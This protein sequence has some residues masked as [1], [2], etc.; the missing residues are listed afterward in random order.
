[1]ML[2]RLAPVGLA[3]QPQLKRAALRTAPRAAYL[4]AL[5]ELFQIND[6]P[7]PNVSK[8]KRPV[9]TPV[10]GLSPPAPIRLRKVPRP[11]C[12]RSCEPCKNQPSTN[13]CTAAIPHRQ[14]S[15]CSVCLFRRM[16][17]PNVLVEAYR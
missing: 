6:S 16:A 3:L 1:M 15:E 4:S 5:T 9:V 8:S 11:W 2:P 17:A 14:E 12:A 7:E 13:M 10:A